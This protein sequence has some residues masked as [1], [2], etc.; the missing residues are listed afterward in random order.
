MNL[1]ASNVTHI[2]VDMLYDFIDG[3]LAAH[4]AR[5]ATENAVKFINE[6]IY[7]R[8][9]Y[10]CDNHPIDHCSFKS[11]GGIWPDHCVQGTRGAQ[12]FD[13]FYSSPALER[14]K[15]H[16]DNTFF[17]GYEKD[18][19]EYSGYNSVNKRGEKLTNYLTKKIV[20]SGI[21]SEFCVKESCYALLSNGYEVYVSRD[22]LAYITLDGH[23]KALKE[24]ERE[25]AIII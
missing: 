18:K 9:L 12:I 23:I 24:M 25:G 11:N 1:N 4:N 8:V 22:N 17:K 6:N 21:A 19:E 5:E 2:V 16:T 15:P 13:H 14:L 3:S 10:V 7:Q 20:I